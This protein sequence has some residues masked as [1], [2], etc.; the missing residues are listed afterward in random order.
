MEKYKIKDIC[1]CLNGRAY[2]YEE[3]QNSGK[4]RILRVGNFFSK[5]DWY[6]SDMELDD[7]KYCYDGDLLYA[8]SA[9]FGPKIWNGEKTI[10]HYHIWKIIPNEN[11]DKMFLYYKLFNMTDYLKGSSHG[12]VMLHLTKSDMENFDIELPHLEHQKK[13]GKI[14]KNIDNKIE[15]NNHINDNL[16]YGT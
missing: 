8:W 13:I 11:V 14:L 5:D 7:N 6:Y 1:T 9:N 16:Y 3:L 4:Y 10:Y 12:T 2:K 15:L